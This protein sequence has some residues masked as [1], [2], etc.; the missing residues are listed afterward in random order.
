MLNAK[1]NSDQTK[2]LQIKNLFPETDFLNPDTQLKLLSDNGLQ[3]K[4]DSRGLKD[5]FEDFKETCLEG[6]KII[7][8][9]NNDSKNK[10]LIHDVQ[11]YMK[12]ETTN[13]Q[14]IVIKSFKI[15]KLDS[16]SFIEKLSSSS[17]LSRNLTIINTL[18]ESSKNYSGDFFFGKN[19]DK[20]IRTFKNELNRWKINLLEIK[21]PNQVKLFLMFITLFFIIVFVAAFLEM[22]FK[23]TK[24][25]ETII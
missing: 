1:N 24:V 15:I 10:F 9:F 19:D 3:M 2:T 13:Y 8:I 21:Y 23:I 22:Y 16:E 11:V 17:K 12:L 4:L 14:K 25:N 6:T 20:E 18:M 5:F 7:R